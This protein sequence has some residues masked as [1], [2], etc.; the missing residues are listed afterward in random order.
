MLANTLWGRLLGGATPWLGCA[1]RWRLANGGRALAAARRPAATN[2]NYR[3]LMLIST[4]G[5][6]VRACFR[7]RCASAS[8]AGLG[9][10]KGSWRLL[11]VGMELAKG[12]PALLQGAGLRN[13]GKNGVDC[14]SNVC[15]LLTGLI[16]PLGAGRAAVD[17]NVR[18][19]YGLQ[20]AE[21]FVM[22]WFFLRPCPLSSFG[23]T[24]SS[25]ACGNNHIHRLLVD[26]YVW[27][28]V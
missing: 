19:F 26:Q 20:S 18:K 7:Y 22:L 16:L 6:M 25:R 28:G 2:G 13:A 4:A 17:S 14:E 23:S 12:P 15:F 24:H 10:V 1:H 21:A 27:D 9:A 8:D 11:A 5:D 3:L